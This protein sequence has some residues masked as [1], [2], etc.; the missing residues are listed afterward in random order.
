MNMLKTIIATVFVATSAS[1]IATEGQIA[2]TT[3][4][5][6]TATQTVAKEVLHLHK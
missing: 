1:A 6:K 5:T 2:P 4:V 3:V